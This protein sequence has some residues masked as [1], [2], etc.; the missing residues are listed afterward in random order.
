[1]RRCRDNI[2]TTDNTSLLWHCVRCRTL[3]IYV[4]LLMSQN[5]RLFR[6]KVFSMTSQDEVLLG[7]L[8][9]YWSYSSKNGQVATGKQE[10]RTRVT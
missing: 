10:I 2:P 6:S 3:Q 5:E 7:R 8:A 1:M 4:Y 9:N